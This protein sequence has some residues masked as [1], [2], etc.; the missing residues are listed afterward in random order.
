MKKHWAVVLPLL[1][2]ACGPKDENGDGIADG[3]R[4]P[5]SVSVVAPANP[6]GTVSG[7]VLDTAMQP[8][9]DASVRL[10]I[11]SDTTEGKYG[12]QTDG[13]GNFMIKNV[14]AGSTV[15]A[16]ISKQGYATLRASAIVPS[17]AGN[18]PIND[19]NASLGLVM[20]AK[21]QSE[22]S[23]TL[24]TDK[25]QPAVGAQA[26]LEAYPAG[27]IAA[28]GTTVQATS[29]VTA[30]PAV[31]DQMGVVKF[32]N[33]PSPS[34][35]TRIGTPPS[36]NTST[37]YYRLW[38]DPV[39]VNGDGIIDSGGYAAP[40]DASVLLKSGSQL[41]TL[42]PAKNNGGANTFT[43]L[44]TNVPSLQL[45]SAEAKKPLRN[46]LRPGE[47]I[48]LG[49][50]QPVARDS[51]VAVLTG[52]Q[53]QTAIE[54]TVK[55]NDTGDAYML[56]P[57]V[58]NTLEGQEYNLI[59]RATSAYSGAV[60]TWKGYFVSG[61]V[62]TPRPLQ[63]ESV[64]FKDGTT[65]TV[66]VLDPG[67]CVILTFNQVVT[68]TAAQLDAFLLSGMDKVY[69]P[70]PAPYPG[71][72]STTPGTCF[73]GEAVKIPIDTASFVATPRFYFTYGTPADTTLP[74]INPNTP[75]ARLRVDFSS[76]QKVDFAQYYETAWGAPVLSTTV[77][78]KAITPPAR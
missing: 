14:P 47:P 59:L 2:L 20:L 54:L 76:F 7:Q 73:A 61:D 30:A 9:A 57:S 49:F 25:G 51:L 43:L 1:V 13:L 32:N 75:T 66:G 48:Y 44:A 70:L 31:A 45:S 11:G 18:I 3:I 60:Q 62:K 5:D 24:L 42:N 15:L 33:M 68:T 35:L 37:A 64:T 71:P 23:F 58:T 36:G 56:T 77:L 78:E 72:N 29:T 10:T 55:S 69:K 50:S 19:G 63:L 39:D 27:L 16:T 21:T 6:K 67:E 38:V 40:I 4:D 65:G 22:V 12:V 46:L 53:G 17:S 34:E 74:P 26:F 52:E 8:L 28:A 41:I